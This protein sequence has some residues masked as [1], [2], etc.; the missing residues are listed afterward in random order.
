M[1]VGNIE[2]VTIL[3]ILLFLTPILWHFYFLGLPRKFYFSKL[4]ITFNQSLKPQ[5]VIAIILIL[6]SWI[7][8]QA[9]FTFDS[10]IVGTAYTYLVI[11]IF[12]YL[13]SLG[14]LNLI[15]L[16]IERKK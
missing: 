7:G 2:S 11:G 1:I 10:I 14:F 6:L 8:N 16:L 5:G 3:V 9:N 15:K 13:P 12:M 4:V